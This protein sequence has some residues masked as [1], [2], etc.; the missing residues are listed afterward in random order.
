MVDVLASA[1]QSTFCLVLGYAW[2]LSHMRPFFSRQIADYRCNLQG[3]NSGNHRK[4]W[5]HHISTQHPCTGESRETA[6]VVPA[7]RNARNCRRHCRSWCV[8]VACGA[9][10][11][12]EGVEGLLAKGSATHLTRPFIALSCLRKKRLWP[13]IWLFSILK[14]LKYRQKYE[15]L[16]RNI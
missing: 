8:L 9:A 1:G 13:G 6:P 4:T 15:I 10:A 11:N 3:W 7:V 12:P 5:I 14:H 16:I 2:I